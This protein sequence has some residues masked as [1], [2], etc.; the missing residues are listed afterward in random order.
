MVEVG[1]ET[2]AS[3]GGR[4]DTSRYE[5]MSSGPKQQAWG[6]PQG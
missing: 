2:L 6:T 1:G 5:Q 4:E 3:K